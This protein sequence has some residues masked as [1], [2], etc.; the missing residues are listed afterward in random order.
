MPQ[1][2][3]GA[4][5]HQASKII[6][7]TIFAKKKDIVPIQ[8]FTTRVE[9]H[10]AISNDYENLNEA[11]KREGFSHIITSGDDVSYYLPAGEYILSGMFTRQQVMDKAKK[12]ASTTTR[13]FSILVTESKGR[14]WHNLP[15]V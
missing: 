9:L 11:M 2:T 13:T 8:Q 7:K 12:A 6:Y 1:I 10:E 5:R 4:K 3:P 15:Q 14:I